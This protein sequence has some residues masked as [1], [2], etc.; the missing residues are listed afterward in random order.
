MTSLRARAANAVL[1]RYVKPTF[2]NG[3][4]L[5]ELRRLGTR[6]DRMSRPPRGTRTALVDLDGLAAE[7]ISTSATHAGGPVI[8]YLPGGGFVLQT[9]RMHRGAAG[10]IAQAAG[11][12][13]LLALYRLAPEHPFPTGVDDCAAAYEYLL[14]EG[15]DP[16][17]IV[18]GGDSA[19]GCLALATLMALRDRGR[20]L[21]RAGF[22]L[23]AVTDLR[24]HRNGSRT[25][26]A[27]LDPMLSIGRSDD[28][29]GTYVGEDLSLLEDPL[30]SPLL[31]DFTGLP[32]LL[33][34]AS[35]IEILLDDSRLAAERA[36][37]AGV[38]CALELYEDVPHA[39]QV[40]LPQLPESRRAIDGIGAFIRHH[41]D[42]R[43]AQA[44][45]A[46]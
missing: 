21:P 35:T 42:P 5:E 30:V 44:S 8:L 19:G 17:R 9:P 37:E 39:W 14:E 23:S 7:R 41:T 1:R 16:A 6:F 36:R 46:H 20:P 27:H 45:R 10:R 4:S 13:A 43:A 29:H 18:I 25:E 38:P 26:N 3:Y 33:L 28:W 15:V 2:Q 22:M 31:G 40:I 24:G 32:P 12:E 11:A 34:Q